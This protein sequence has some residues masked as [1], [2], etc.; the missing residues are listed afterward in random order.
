MKPLSFNLTKLATIN[1]DNKFNII[2]LSR[3]KF[4]AFAV[5]A[6][7]TVISV[8]NGDMIC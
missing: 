1:Y 6:G 5:L 3:N 7:I 4:G 2:G 8:D